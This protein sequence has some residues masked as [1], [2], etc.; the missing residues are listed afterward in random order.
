MNLTYNDLM[1]PKP[2]AP[3][4]QVWFRL[5]LTPFFIDPSGSGNPRT[6]GFHG[7]DF[8]LQYKNTREF[9]EDGTLED[10]P[11]C[12]FAAYRK[13]TSVDFEEEEYWSG[14]LTRS[15]VFDQDTNQVRVETVEQGNHTIG[16]THTRT[17][18]TAKQGDPF[19]DPPT[20][21]EITLSEAV[22]KAWLAGELQRWMDEPDDF[23]EA[24][25]GGLGTYS[26]IGQGATRSESDGYLG[27]VGGGDVV[28][29]GPWFYGEPF[30]MVGDE[31]EKWNGRF[32]TW[33]NRVRRKNAPVIHRESS[34]HDGAVYLGSSNLAVGDSIYRD[35]YAEMA[36]SD[37]IGDVWMDGHGVFQESDA[38]DSFPMEAAYA[39]DFHGLV[40]HT[41]DGEANELTL[42]SRTGKRYRVTIQTGRNEYNEDGSEWVTSQSHVLTTDASTLQATL[43]LEENEDAW[44]IRVARIEE[45][46]TIEGQKQWRVVADADAYA[47]YVKDLQAW[48]TAWDAWDVG[49]RVGDAPI[50]PAE[51]KYPASLIGPD[52]VGS[53]LLLAAMKLRS[54]TRFGFSPLVYSEE[55]ANDRYRKRT[56]KLHLTPGTVE[57][58]EG[59]CGLATISGSADLEWSEEFD[60]ETGLQLPR[61]VGQ[62]QLSINGQDW[63]QESYAEF[64]S[65]FFNGSTSKVQT[66]TKIRREGTY[67]WAGRFL[68][69]FDAPDPRGKVLSTGWAKAAMSAVD[70]RNESEALT[71]DPPA[72]GGSV[73]FE[74]HRLTYDTGA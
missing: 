64:D 5:P 65:V 33:I 28:A 27:I 54:G 57:S 22:D 42:V 13:S 50:K 21:I 9:K 34:K 1:P 12:G 37:L 19:E 17:A 43:T 31:G 52:V 29:F 7:D 66:A 68:V 10:E 70:E 2:T 14:T 20:H 69:A 26:Y 32:S 55:T 41:G 74:G 56:F 11:I 39:Y 44:E 72:A 24:T 40:S 60:A 59:A 18:T 16:L 48:Q 30:G 58:H 63:T 15:Y 45:E 71:L 61:E 51:Q 25:G 6:R 47:Q 38:L 4:K 3:I 73:F 8:F 46:V 36:L 62:W 23:R 49:G 67:T 35:G 53:Y